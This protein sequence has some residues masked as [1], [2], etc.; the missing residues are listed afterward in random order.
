MSKEGDRDRE[1]SKVC[2]VCVCVCVCVRERE[3]E[4]EKDM[5]HCVACCGFVEEGDV[6]QNWYAQRSLHTIL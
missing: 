3:R 4:R 6:C 5:V 1:Y 2:V